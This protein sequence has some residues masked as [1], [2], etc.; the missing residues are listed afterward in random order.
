MSQLAQT[1]A[2][3]KELPMKNSESQEFE[4][5]FVR[6]LRF[7]DFENFEK[8]VEVALMDVAEQAANWIEAL[9]M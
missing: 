8:M 9:E 2:K 3:M 1:V 6:F 4:R 7:N 5:E